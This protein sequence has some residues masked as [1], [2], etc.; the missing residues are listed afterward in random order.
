MQCGDNETTIKRI[1]SEQA[2]VRQIL[3]TNFFALDEAIKYGGIKGVLGRKM[4]DVP[5]CSWRL[6]AWLILRG[7]KQGPICTF[8]IFQPNMSIGRRGDNIYSHKT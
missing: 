6:T 8:Y 2:S 1:Q 3:W 7:A 5:A 4:Y